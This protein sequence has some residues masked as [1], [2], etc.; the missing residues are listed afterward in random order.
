VPAPVAAAA[1]PGRRQ[2]RS[3]QQQQQQQQRHGK[4]SGIYDCPQQKRLY[5]HISNR[6]NWITTLSA[7]DKI[8]E[9]DKKKKGIYEEVTYSSLQ[10]PF[11]Q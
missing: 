9:L 3:L 10:A 4:V 5:L 2:G 8:T 11:V 6:K 7:A 1:T